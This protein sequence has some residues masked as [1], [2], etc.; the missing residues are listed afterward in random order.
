MAL[1]YPEIVQVVRLKVVP[2]GGGRF[3]TQDVG[4]LPVP[5]LLLRLREIR[6][7]SL[8]LNNEDEYLKTGGAFTSKFNKVE[9]LPTKLLAVTLY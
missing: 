7:L 6:S 9:E 2:I 8:K 3:I 5:S 1:A 4:E